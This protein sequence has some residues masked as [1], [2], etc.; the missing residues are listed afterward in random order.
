MISF[1]STFCSA[2]GYPNKNLYAP[3]SFSNEVRLYVDC[4]ALSTSGNCTCDKRNR[5]GFL[6]DPC[7]LVSEHKPNELLIRIYAKILYTHIHG[8]TSYWRLLGTY[9]LPCT[10]Q[11]H[12]SNIQHNMQH[13]VA[14]NSRTSQGTA[15]ASL[16]RMSPFLLL[17][18]LCTKHLD[19][20]FCEVAQH[21]APL[22]NAHR[23]YILLSM[24][25]L[26]FVLH[27]LNCKH[28]CNHHSTGH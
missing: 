18:C 12:S 22:L 25:Q 2:F 15:V 16:Q 6:A 4:T 26:C 17:H 28:A 9:A 27:S 13:I 8:T 10:L 24:A 14:T 3:V 20:Q 1:R 11:G 19:W 21:L 5:A 23:I 7:I